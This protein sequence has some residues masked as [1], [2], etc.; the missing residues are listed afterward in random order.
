MLMAQCLH[1]SERFLL[2]CGDTLSPLAINITIET[3][4]NNSFNLNANNKNDIIL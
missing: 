3:I 4:K 1:S 2:K